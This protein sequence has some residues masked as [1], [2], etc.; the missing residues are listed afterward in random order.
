MSSNKLLKKQ[1][2]SDIK[3]T[4]KCFYLNLIKLLSTHSVQMSLT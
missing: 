2:T 4:N 1:R 3:I